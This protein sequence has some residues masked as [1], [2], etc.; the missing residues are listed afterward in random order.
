MGKKSAGIIL[1]K[2]E[3][4]NIFVL[5]GHMGGPFWWKKDN[6]AWTI[7]KGQVESHESLIE[8]AIREFHEETGLLIEENLIPLK[9]VRQS[10]NKIIHIWAHNTDVNP[11]ILESNLF[12][13]EWPPK[14]GKYQ[15]FPELDRFEWFSLKKA[16]I[17]I[18]KG[19]LPILDQLK[20]ITQ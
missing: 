19:Q 9:S 17:K 12:E 14:S 4:N 18:V 16:K 13:M 20:D 6:R 2:K 15:L 11:K 7:P 3:K 5:L 10:S 8:A 1:F